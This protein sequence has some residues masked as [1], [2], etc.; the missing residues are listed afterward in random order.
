MPEDY[1]VSVGWWVML[2]FIPGINLYIFYTIGKLRNYLL[3][4]VIPASIL[5]SSIYTYRLFS[6]DFNRWLTNLGSSGLGETIVTLY[7]GM[8]VQGLAVFLAVTWSRQ[9]NRKVDASTGQAPS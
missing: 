7:I 4:V 5:L 3:Y 2:S 8:A 9:H 1:E 6:V